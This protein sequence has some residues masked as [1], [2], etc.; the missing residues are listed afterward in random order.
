MAPL[1]R[2]TTTSI[3]RA[4]AAAV[5]KKLS[6]R[7]MKPSS[8]T[9]RRPYWSDSAPSTEEPKKLAI[10]NEAATHRKACACSAW[11]L[12]KL[13]AISGSTGMISP[14]L[15]MSISTVAKMKAIEA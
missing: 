2:R 10:P 5:T 4:V 3:H 15:T 12:E 1:N 6:A 8:S 14:M 13:P 7:P 11:V 9:G